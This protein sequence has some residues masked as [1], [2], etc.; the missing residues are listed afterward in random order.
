MGEYPLS[1]RAFGL[2]VVELGLAGVG[3]VVAAAGLGRP[4]PRRRPIPW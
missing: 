1:R 2:R 4:S 3:P